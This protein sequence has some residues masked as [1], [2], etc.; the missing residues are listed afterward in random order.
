MATKTSVRKG[1]VYRDLHSFR[2]GRR[3][4]I[5]GVFPDYDDV[6]VHSNR[7]RTTWIGLDRFRDGRFELVKNGR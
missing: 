4:T 2:R 5:L 1:Q 3:V 7:N 6:Q